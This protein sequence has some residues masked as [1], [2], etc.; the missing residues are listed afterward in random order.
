M[1]LKKITFYHQNLVCWLRNNYMQH[2]L[3][4]QFELCYAYLLS[5]S[6]LLCC[7][8]SPLTFSLWF[9]QCFF[10]WQKR[11]YVSNY[12]DGNFKRMIVWNIE[13][14]SKWFIFYCRWN[15]PMNHFQLDMKNIF[16]TAL[17]FLT[18]SSKTMISDFVLN[19]KVVASVVCAFHS[20]IINAMRAKISK[21]IKKKW[22]NKLIKYDH[23]KLVI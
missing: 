21:T 16:R 18:H 6:P 14:P 5:L 22:M 23:K 13:Y 15:L 1:P 19:K 9:G 12:N 10:H 7:Q 4:W 8:S 11:V 3:S 20:T 17:I 2:F